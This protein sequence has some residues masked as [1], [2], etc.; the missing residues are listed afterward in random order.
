MRTAAECDPTLDG[1]ADQNRD[2][3]QFWR[4]GHGYDVRARRERVVH[5]RVDNLAERPLKPFDFAG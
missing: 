5:P 4:V 1:R 2:L 3:P